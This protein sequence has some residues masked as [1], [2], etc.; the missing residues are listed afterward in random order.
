MP[1]VF[2]NIIMVRSFAVRLQCF[3]AAGSPSA[4]P[5][6]ASIRRAVALL[7]TREKGHVTAALLPRKVMKSHRRM[8]HPEQTRQPRKPNLA[9]LK[10]AETTLSAYR[11]QVKRD[12]KVS[13]HS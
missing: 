7:G 3:P 12:E 8:A 10:S 1:I 6:S 9:N 5:N 4:F 2:Y 11:R 13:S